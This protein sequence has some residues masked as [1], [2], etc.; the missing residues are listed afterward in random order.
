[1]SFMRLLGHQECVTD[2]SLQSKR[3]FQK[4]KRG[5]GCTISNRNT[6]CSELS[7]T[8]ALTCCGGQVDAVIQR[9]RR[10]RLSQAQIPEI[11]RAGIEGGVVPSLNESGMPHVPASRSI[12]PQP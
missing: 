7:E 6:A 5:C 2:L 3:V 10:E 9:A 1:M 8:H 4:M 11:S 12:W